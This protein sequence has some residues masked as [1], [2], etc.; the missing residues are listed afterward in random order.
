MST[1]ALQVTSLSPVDRVK[2]LFDYANAF[3]SNRYTEIAIIDLAGR[4][5]VASTAGSPSRRN[6]ALPDGP[7]LAALRDAVHGS[8]VERD[9]RALLPRA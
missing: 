4:T 2:V 1:S 5:L 7:A 9:P 6:L 8:G 3:G